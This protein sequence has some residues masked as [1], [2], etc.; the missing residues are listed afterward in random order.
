MSNQEKIPSFED[1]RAQLENLDKDTETNNNVNTKHNPTEVPPFYNSEERSKLKVEDAEPKAKE[2]VIDLVKVVREFMKDNPVKLLICTPCY[3]GQ[4]FLGYH[5]SMILLTSSFTKLGINFEVMCLG[6]ESL[7]TR[8]RNG[9]SARFMGDESFTHMMFID[10]DITFSWLSVLRLIL[11]DKDLSGGCYPKKM[12]NWDKVKH[13]VKKDENLPED[14]LLSKS[15]DYVFNPVYYKDGDK[16]VAKTENGMVRVKDVA[17]GFMMIKRNVFT[18]L[19][20][21]FPEL[22]FKNNV[23]GYH[24]KEAADYFYTFFDTVIDDETGV[25]LSEDY[26]FCKLWRE[27]GGELWLDLNT[28]LT[29]TGTMDFRGSLMM[30][31]GEFDHLN[32]DSTVTK[33]TMH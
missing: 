6:N 29:H 12:I 17:T 11:S 19:M 4:L 14:V 15:L 9:M 24:R 27:C 8:A 16:V 20:Y 18:T 30:N 22:K 33:N 10:A 26:Y 25:Y 3:G 13:Q 7:I 31:I 2:K 21:K 1:F 5:Q 32:K 23:A 28:N